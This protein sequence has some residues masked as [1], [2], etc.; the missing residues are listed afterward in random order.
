VSEADY[1]AVVADL[2][3]G[4][5]SSPDALLSPLADRI[6]IHAG[7]HRFEEAAIAR[8]RHRALAA[9]LDRRR[10][11]G[12]LVEVGVLWAADENGDS[13]LIENGRLLASWTD[14]SPPPLIPVVSSPPATEQVPPS[15][16]VAEEADILW[17]WLNRSDVRIVDAARP[18]SLP[19]TPVRRIESLAS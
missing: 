16:G 7:Q 8:D 4:I 14:P 2:T 6:R 12:A 17:R 13:V 3:T 5:A 15:I 10:N 18:M 1:A 19:L 9:A 11:W